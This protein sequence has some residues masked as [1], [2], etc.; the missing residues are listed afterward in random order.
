MHNI[1]LRR[2][3]YDAGENRDSSPI[4]EMKRR[5][6]A[7]RDDISAADTADLSAES[8][9]RNNT[10]SFRRRSTEH[11]GDVDITSKPMHMQSSREND[12]EFLDLKAP[13][14]MK[15]NLNTKEEYEEMIQEYE[16][17]IIR[18]EKLNA[19]LS[20]NVAALYAENAATEDELH[21]LARPGLG[22]KQTSMEMSTDEE[23]TPLDNDMILTEDQYLHEIAKHQKSNNKL[24]KQLETQK[25]LVSKLSL[26]LKTSADKITALNKEK[27]EF[28]TKVAQVDDIAIQK[29]V[30][31]TRDDQN[32]DVHKFQ[33]QVIQNELVSLQNL[34]IQNAKTHRRDRQQML[35]EYRSEDAL[36]TSKLERPMD[37]MKRIIQSVTGDIG[38]IDNA[39][40]AKP[41]ATLEKEK[42]AMSTGFNILDS[43]TS[44][45]G[46]NQYQRT[47]PKV[48]VDEHPVSNEIKTY[49]V[50]RL[51]KTAVALEESPS[52]LEQEDQVLKENDNDEETR[53]E[54]ETEEVAV[55]ELL[56]DVSERSSHI[57]ILLDDNEKDDPSECDD[58][59]PILE[60]EVKGVEDSGDDHYKLPHEDADSDSHLTGGANK[61]AAGFG[62]EN[63]V[64]E[65]LDAA[66]LFPWTNEEKG[67]E[68]GDVVDNSSDEESMYEAFEGKY[69]AKEGKGG[70]EHSGDG[71][72]DSKVDEAGLTSD[73]V[74][75][76]TEE[77]TTDA[78]Q[79]QGGGST[80][81]SCE[82]KQEDKPTELPQVDFVPN[83]RSS[84]ARG[85]GSGSI[86]MGTCNTFATGITNGTQ[87]RVTA[88]KEDKTTTKETEEKTITPHTE[89]HNEDKR[90]ANDDREDEKSLAHYQ[91]VISQFTRGESRG[92][93]WSK[94]SMNSKNSLSRK[95]LFQREGLSCS[96]LFV[97]VVDDVFRSPGERKVLLASKTGRDSVP[98]YE[99]P[100]LPPERKKDAPH[101]K[102]GMKDGY[103][104]YKSSSGNEYSGHWK[105]GRRHGY[106]M[107]KYRDGEVF[108]GDWRR[109]RR[110]GHGVLHLAN[111]DVFDG[112]W[113]TNQ[114]NGLGV[115][116]WA[117]G[118]VDISW[119]DKDTRSE[120]VRWNKDRRIAYML[121]LKSSKK[122]QISLSKAAKIV[123]EWEK[124]AEVFDC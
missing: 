37:T 102:R 48:Q 25:K 100:T 47:Q 94:N 111:K 5:N 70:V 24:K 44:L 105:G 22:T 65:E 115:Y 116:Y 3:S 53:F 72:T 52:K 42:S 59:E 86:S 106:G 74:A 118:E 36:W 108:H 38:G 124:K 120:S 66:A 56:M 10:G 73:P 110:H 33:V 81:V 95:Q 14:P 55:V 17:E 109:G 28:K 16:G 123:R 121:D 27:D 80:V 104:M 76:N 63:D 20:A 35:E 15:P 7:N 41:A 89:Y 58:T 18:L 34:M 51:K 119:Y 8:G 83:R 91:N 12:V 90:T 21:G 87:A 26:H 103:Y 19:N 6:Y 113:D 85:N 96:D 50:S 71:T 64:V 57:E 54:L 88:A 77:I 107:A 117:D 29:A 82:T 68:E 93:Q 2:K 13:A 46:Q 112:D 9:E 32:Q 11:I 30:Q 49:D 99:S 75:T 39:P 23:Y 114:K 40:E 78:D 92:S 45:F 60:H 62:E 61:T 69:V 31:T 43:M 67:H 1:L 101:F 98:P 79:L 84:M 122:E 4:S 97:D